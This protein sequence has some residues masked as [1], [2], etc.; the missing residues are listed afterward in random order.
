[1]RLYESDSETVV[2]TAGAWPVSRVRWSAVLAGVVTLLS[3][4][5][6]L[7]GLA[8]AIV[9]LLGRPTV[10]STHAGALAL[11]IC[12]MATTLVG[13]IAGGWVSGRSLAGASR[14]F[15]AAHGFLTW[16]AALLI[17]FGFQMFAL[18]GLV[19]A[20]VSDASD[21]AAMNAPPSAQPDA[22]AEHMSWRVARD[23]LAGGS[24]SWFA[25]W[26]VAGIAASAAAAAAGRAVPRSSIREMPADEIRQRP[27]TPTTVP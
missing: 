1:M 18:R 7:W 9:T 8:F 11:W 16:G 6:L 15:G 21:A 20:A 12:A 14:G 5:L 23:Y 4:A 17:S 13:A 2:T 22:A 25:T 27:L 24:W 10:A 19:T 26:L 3:V